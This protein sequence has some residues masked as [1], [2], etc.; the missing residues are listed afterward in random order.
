MF[1]VGVLP[2]FLVL[3]IRR[4]VPEPEEWHFARAQAGSLQM[5]IRQLFAPGVGRT[6]LLTILVCSLTLTAHWAFQFWF[7]QH[8]K[9]LP[10]TKSWS[11]VA[12]QQLVAK[13]VFLVLIT[14]IAGRL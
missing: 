12:K 14:S 6:T 1:L 3:W 11:A 9:N 7:P 4:A 13:A 2:A 8:L 10:D 5:G